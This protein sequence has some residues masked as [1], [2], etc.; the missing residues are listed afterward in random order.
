[1]KLSERTNAVRLRRAGVSYAEIQQQL[2]VTKSTLWRR[3]KRDGLVETQPQR[4]TDL[5]RLAQRKAATAVKDPRLQR[6]A[7]IV[8][9]AR[10]EIGSLS[11]RDLWLLGA[12]LYWAEGAKQRPGNVSA[13]VVFGNS[14]PTAVKVFAGWL[15]DIC[16][17]SASQIRF[18]LYLHETAD[19]D[20]ARRYWAEQ[21]G[22]PVERLSRVRWK[23]HRPSARRTNVGDS[24]H[25]LVRVSVAQSSALN[26][27]ITGWI[28]GV[29]DSLGSSVMAAQG[30]LDPH[31]QVRVLAP[32]P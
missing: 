26:R 12:A 5:K 1:M 31:V 20:R 29:G 19:A 27:R 30:T 7:A 15:Q 3:L 21:L 28:L 13:G 22:L 4:L 16:G 25:G 18:E 6:T 32:Q 2:R 17:V 24:Y 14:D 8:D 23:H 11:R 10:Q 9:E